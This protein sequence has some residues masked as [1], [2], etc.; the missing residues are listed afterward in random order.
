MMLQWGIYAI[1]AISQ[2]KIL[3]SYCLHILQYTVQSLLLLEDLS[4]SAQRFF[5]PAYVAEKGKSTTD[6]KIRNAEKP[7]INV[8]FKNGTVSVP[9][10][11]DSYMMYVLNTGSPI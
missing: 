9:A 8:F 10:V 5:I 7:S 1:L 6:P 3:F 2:R 11:I 4:I